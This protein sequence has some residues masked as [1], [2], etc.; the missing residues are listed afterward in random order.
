LP[1]RDL[2]SNVAWLD[3]SVAKGGFLCAYRWNDEHKLSND[4]FA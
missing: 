4:H 3:F 1:A 2:A